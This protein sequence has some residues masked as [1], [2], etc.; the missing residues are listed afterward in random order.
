MFP[1]YFW[2]W[3]AMRN[4]A[5]AMDIPLSAPQEFTQ[6]GGVNRLWFVRKEQRP[7]EPRHHYT[8]LF[9]FCQGLIFRIKCL[10]YDSPQVDAILPQNRIFVK[11]QSLRF[12]KG[13]IS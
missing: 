2:C 8:T 3:K 5:M 4:S 1:P 13:S 10:F 6:G 7:Y 9:K 11:G 12:F